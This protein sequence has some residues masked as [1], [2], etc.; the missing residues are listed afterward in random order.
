[1]I[2]DELK[3]LADYIDQIGNT[4]DPNSDEWHKIACPGYDAQGKPCNHPICVA[5][6]QAEEE[7]YRRQEA[8]NKER[9]FMVAMFREDLCGMEWVLKAEPNKYQ[10]AILKAWNASAPL[11]I[12]GPVG[13]G[14]TSGALMVL[15][16]EKVPPTLISAS[17]L[18]IVPFSRILECG[19]ADGLIIDDIGTEN[20]MGLV[21]LQTILNA[22]DQNRKP[23]IIT[24]N[25]TPAE[26]KS[27]YDERIRRRLGQILDL[28][29]GKIFILG[30]SVGGQKEN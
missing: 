5:R 25:L 14:K 8:R 1:M 28:R 18:G 16:R 29:G 20:E 26:L 6:R 12:S 10:E 27:R 24:T 23:T 2:Y 21:N 13:S 19:R 9:A 7:A 11:T 30:G 15:W 3:R 4:I 17:A 22:R